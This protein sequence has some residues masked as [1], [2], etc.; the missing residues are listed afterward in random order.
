METGLNVYPLTISDRLAIEKLNYCGYTAE[1]NDECKCFFFEER[2]DFYNELE[3]MIA[4]E[5]G[6][7]VNYRIERI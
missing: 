4:V 5:L 6:H 3:D 7:N 1:W 2:E